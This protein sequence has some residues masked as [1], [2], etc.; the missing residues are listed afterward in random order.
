MHFLL[1]E[2]KLLAS[3]VYPL[4]TPGYNCPALWLKE[5]SEDDLRWLWGQKEDLLGLKVG[6]SHL[7]S[8]GNTTKIKQKQNITCVKKNTRKSKQ[9]WKSK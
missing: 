5:G 6:F 7:F 4:L 1:E 9:K 3:K 2:K 8:P